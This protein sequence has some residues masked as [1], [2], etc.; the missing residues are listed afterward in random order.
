MDNRSAA[1]IQY[2]HEKPLGYFQCIIEK[3]QENKFGNTFKRHR[4]LY[5]S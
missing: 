2:A 3:L 5:E 1:C 4:E